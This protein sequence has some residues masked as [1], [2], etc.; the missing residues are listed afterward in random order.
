[1]HTITLSG[2]SP[3]PLAHYLKALG[4]FRVIS[5]SEHGDINATVYWKDNSFILN[6]K[7][8][9]VEE[10]SLPDFFFNNYIPTPIMVP[11]SGGDFFGVNQEKPKKLFTKT[12]TA[13]LVIESFLSNDSP[14][15][16]TYRDALKS[17]FSAMNAAGVKVKK[18]IEGSGT[19]Q[20][21]LKA[22]MLKSLRNVLPDNTLTWMD[23]ASIIE[24]DSVA[25]N[26]LLGGGGGS[27][28]NSHFS[29]NFMQCLWMALPDFDAQREKPIRA[30]GKN[31]YFD[32][33][34]ALCESLFGLQGV[35]TKIPGLS[36]V[37]FDS[38][39]VGGPN[40]T[41]G[42]EAK[43]GSNPWDFIL[44]L[45]G[46]VLFAGAIGRKLDT[47][48]DP[49]ARFPFLFQSSPVGLGASFP[50]ESSGRELWLPLWSHPASLSEVRA[51]FAEGRVEKHGRMARRGCDAFVAAAQLGFD[52]GIHAFQRIGFY[53]GR[54]G[55]DNY[56]TAVDQ[57]RI[58]PRRNQSVDLLRD[59]DNWFD[60]LTSI[61]VSDKCP[62]SVAKRV[63]ALE[64]R[65]ADLSVAPKHE[66]LQRFIDVIIAIG[67]TERA[68]ARSFHWTTETA[69]IKPLYGL[70][71]QWCKMIN[72]ITS[73]RLQSPPELR[74]AASLAGMYARLRKKTLHFRQHLEPVNIF[75]SESSRK[76][77]WKQQSDNDVVWQSGG[78]VDSLNAILIRRVIRFEKAGVQGWPDESPIY[79]GLDD[80]TAFIEGR[81]DEQLLADLIW[82]LSLLD[83]DIKSSSS[84]ESDKKTMKDNLE[85]ISSVTPSSFYALL[86]LCFSP[87]K[88]INKPIPVVPQI[89]HYA[90]NGKGA[91]A[92]QLASRRLRA[93]GCFPLVRDLPVSKTLA[94]R[95]AA[96]MLFPISPDD[97][98]SIKQYI[99]KK[100]N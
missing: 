36:P 6:S 94:E 80:I 88:T 81:I 77:D 68:V 97:Y 12:P 1:M 57:G 22:E 23:A 17:T 8:D 61:Y 84:I 67:A 18:D 35:G 93:S 96:A 75:I 15:L 58:I 48:H 46:S 82:G 31:T 100:I 9:R 19:A 72:E 70:R 34:A 64:R 43:A 39:R 83:W 13:S 79:A 55:G 59:I 32:S 37:L 14:R 56:F 44:M 95:T 66:S 76:V 50:G 42:F 33:R 52:R 21:Y 51:V 85:K 27:D 7:F 69:H 91:E 90:V 30:I 47:N 25:F 10:P 38:T 73:S 60:K 24:S 5:E 92:S 11:W 71:Q 86:R 26:T 2:C 3:I 63:V 28:G 49:S 65:I 87:A 40:Q 98:E 53:K 41:S 20:R 74:L 89:L 4:I 45:E 54:I 16:K 78:L 99:L 62:A 29:D